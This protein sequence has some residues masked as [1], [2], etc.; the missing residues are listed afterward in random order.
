MARAGSTVAA[1]DA[2]IRLVIGESIPPKFLEI[3]GRYLIDTSGGNLANL[4]VKAM[5]RPLFENVE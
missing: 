1:S 5:Q 2:L 3:L 4:K